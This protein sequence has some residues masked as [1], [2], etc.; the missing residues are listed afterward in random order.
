MI[1]SK[2]HKRYRFPKD[3]EEGLPY[4]EI[5]ENGKRIKIC[6]NFDKYYTSSYGFQ[7]PLSFNSSIIH[8][9]FLRNE[10]IL[11]NVPRFLNLPEYYEKGQE[12]RSEIDDKI[13]D[14]IIG[15]GISGI[16]ALENCKNCV[17]ISQIFDDEIFL[18]PTYEDNNFKNRIKSIIKENNNRIIE[19]KFV[20]AFDE[21]LVFRLKD[22][23]LIIRKPAKIILASG[24]RFLPPI[25]PGN[26]LPGIISRRMY[27]KFSNIFKNIVVIGSTD[28]AI[29]T[30]LIS[31]SK[32]ILRNGTENFSKKYLELAENKGIDFLKVTHLKASRKGK[33][34]ILTHDYG[35][36]VVDAVV[37]AIVRQPRIEIASNLGI[38]Y[39]YYSGAHIYLPIS[40]IKGKVNNT[41][42]VTGGMRGI[43]D[44]ELSFISGKVIFD[45]NID[46]FTARLKE[47][48]IYQKKESESPYFFGNGYICECEDVKLNEIEEQYKKGYKSVEEMKRTLGIS[49]GYC[50]GKICSFLAGDYLESNK[51][52][53]FRSP[54]YPMW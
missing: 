29:R 38:E 52:I 22:K 42:Y 8:S 46:E 32:V 35:K 11:N 41:Y 48:Y 19:G 44:Y 15:G 2:K 25:F 54:L 18:D 50:Q 3:C 36:E 20:G 6:E 34:I 5:V 31:K 51:L 39:S 53:T 17:L 14:I 30:A 16:S 4:T 7:L 24:S 9:K 21:G 13:T 26:D 45:E 27:L 33:K 12:I 28:D 10:F 49:T 1:K 23:Y 47:T 37:F 40:D 43:S